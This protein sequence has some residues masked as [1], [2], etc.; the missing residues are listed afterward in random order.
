MGPNRRGQGREGLR[1]GTGPTGYKWAHRGGGM[2]TARRT[3]AALMER[4]TGAKCTGGGRPPITG[5]GCGGGAIDGQGIGGEGWGMGPSETLGQKG[6]AVDTGRARRDAVRGGPS[7]GATGGAT[8]LYRQGAM[9]KAPPDR[10]PPLDPHRASAG[11]TGLRGPFGTSRTA[12]ER[13]GDIGREGANG[14]AIRGRRGDGHGAEGREGRGEA[15]ALGWK[16]GARGMGQRIRWSRGP[17]W[18]PAA[19][20][21]RGGGPVR[22]VDRWAGGS[23]GTGRHGVWEGSA[24]V[25]TRCCT[26]G[27]PFG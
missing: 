16:D 5:C 27:G 6:G 11:N 18:L 3:G 25:C 17:T 19:Q 8:E 2:S 26:F 14:R 13:N 9:G 1:G 23:R 12:T 20:S 4:E 22:P 15:A 7:G 21:P 10:R 24:G